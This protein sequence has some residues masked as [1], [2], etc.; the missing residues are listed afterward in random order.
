[1]WVVKLGGSLM[2]DP[3]L[4]EWLFVLAEYGAGRV[5]I[6][7][8][9]GRFKDLIHKL[10]KRWRIDD[11]IAHCMAILA[12]R[13]TGLLFLGLEAR[14]E[15]ARTEQIAGVLNRGK[16]AVWLPEVAELDRAKVPSNWAV[17][18][19]SLAAWLAGRLCAHSLVLVK[20]KAPESCDP[21]ELKNRGIVDEAFLDWLP[22]VEFS[23]LSKNDW[24]QFSQKLQI[25][26]AP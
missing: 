24:A 11:R 26:G 8:G 2:E 25:L 23:C 1:M 18:S 3:S 15:L 16:T 22:Q 10:Q 7:P 19:D 6:V 4:K 9:G 21:V 13:Q 20:S 12:M 14:L 5:V 17:T